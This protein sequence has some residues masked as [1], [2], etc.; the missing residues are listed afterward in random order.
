MR[1]LWNVWY[2][3]SKYCGVSHEGYWNS[4]HAKFQLE[5]VTDCLKVL[6]PYFDIAHLYDQSAGH[7]KYARTDCR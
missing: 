3:G 2:T 7:T 4:S 1:M 5:D 6:Y